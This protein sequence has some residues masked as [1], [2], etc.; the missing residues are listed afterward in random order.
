MELSAHPIA[1][2]NRKKADNTGRQDNDP[3]KAEN[4]FIMWSKT[5][6]IR[7]CDQ[8]IVRLSASMLAAIAVL[9]LP[10]TAV[11]GFHSVLQYQKTV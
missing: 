10:L 7:S 11:T 3:G 8:T 6:F 5:I 4:V 9:T 1:E 2:T